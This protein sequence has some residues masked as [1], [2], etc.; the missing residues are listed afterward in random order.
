MVVAIAAQAP[1]KDTTLEK[2][3]AVPTVNPDG[4][5]QRSQFGIDECKI[6]KRAGISRTKFICYGVLKFAPRRN[7]TSPEILTLLKGNHRPQ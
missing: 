2:L 4:I 6:L 3:K 1:T 5:N 7:D